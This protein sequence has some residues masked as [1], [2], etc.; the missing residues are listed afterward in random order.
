M[1][2]WE[3]RGNRGYGPP[4]SI[5]YPHDVQAQMPLKKKWIAGLLAFF[6]PGT[7]HLYLGQ[8]AKGIAI[9]LMIAFDI[10]A[11][12]FAAMNHF[13]VLI[14]V[15]LSLFLPIIYFYS[16]FDAIQSTDIV[17]YRWRYFGW[18]APAFGQPEAYAGARSYE[19]TDAA[20]H[21]YDGMSSSSP[22]TAHASASAFANQASAGPIPQSQPY[23]E[24][25]S[26]NSYTD[27]EAPPPGPS[28]QP[29]RES[30]NLSRQIGTPGIL[31]LAAAII[32][33]ILFAGIGSTGWVYRSSGSAAG[34]VVLIA[35]GIGLW[36]WEWKGDR[37][38][39]S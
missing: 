35:A 5:P 30:W 11:I 13:P 12:V 18:Q 27:G 7:G 32:A 33:L 29:H 28:P 25:A 31:L 38:K 14:V 16:L 17:N 6:I 36:L 26:A 34:A 4:Q 3:H 9:M 37:S 10:C 19:A 39:R 2:D 23:G 22:H 8:M 20:P 15:L 1:N 24:H 21:D